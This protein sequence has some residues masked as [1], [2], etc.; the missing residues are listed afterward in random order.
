[1]PFVERVEWGWRRKWNLRIRIAITDQ[2]RFF[3]DSQENGFNRFGTSPLTTSNFKKNSKTVSD[4]K[5]N[6]TLK[7]K[8]GENESL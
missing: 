6:S 4:V 1:L 3:K 2:K 8:I 5:K 7:Q